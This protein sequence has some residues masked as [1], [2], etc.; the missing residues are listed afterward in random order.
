MTAAGL[1]LSFFLGCGAGWWVPALGRWALKGI[2]LNERID[3]FRGVPL[4]RWGWCVGLGIS[5][6]LTGWETGSIGELLLGW[7]LTLFLAVAVWTDLGTG[8]I[9]NRWVVMG[10][11]FFFLGRAIISWDEFPIY[12]YGAASAAVLLGLVAWLTGGM[13]GGDVK[14]AGAAGLVLGIGPVLTGIALA[15]CIGGVWSSWLLLS[16]GI[17]LKTAIPFGPHLAAGFLVSFVWGEELL[18]WYLSF[19]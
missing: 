4:P 6:V 8:L 13:G 3:R 17:R 2:P 7:S 19:L 18:R 10:A 15:I 12:L 11:L 1:G 16:R 9:P 14:L 5:W